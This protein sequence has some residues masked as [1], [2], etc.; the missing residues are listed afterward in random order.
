MAPGVGNAAFNMGPLSRQGQTVVHRIKYLPSNAVLCRAWNTRL[1]LT[2]APDG[3]FA[4]YSGADIGTAFSL[5]AVT[6]DAAKLS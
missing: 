4:V 1:D 3:S 2:G 6:P 5:K